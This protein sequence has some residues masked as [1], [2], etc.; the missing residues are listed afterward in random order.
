MLMPAVREYFF[1]RKHAFIAGDA[2]LLWDRYPGLQNGT[3]LSRGINAEEFYITNMQG[4]KPFDGNIF[5]E[6]Y[7][8]LRVKLEGEQAQVLVH[9]MELYL[10]KDES[11]KFDDSGGEFKIILFLQQEGS[12][13]TVIRTQD[14]SGP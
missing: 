13:W 9:G 12:G 6:Y 7:E 14:I 1:I 11:G 4:L 5:P 10:W 8:K 2:Q 3:D